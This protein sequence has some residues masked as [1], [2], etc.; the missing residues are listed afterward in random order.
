MPSVTQQLG[1]ALALAAAFSLS[2]AAVAQPPPPPGAG[3]GELQTPDRNNTASVPNA[4][5]AP[6]HDLNITRQPIP[7]VLLAA[8][9]NPYDP[10]RPLNCARISQQLLVLQAALGPDLDEPETPQSPSLTLHNGRI[11]LALLHGA[12]ESL[13][14]FA[15]FV[16]TL[17]G[18]GHHDELVIEAITAGS[19]RR[20]YLKGMG[21]AMNCPHPARPVH[22]LHPP[23]PAREDGP[24]PKY[25]IN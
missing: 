1:A 8:I 18:A 4:V 10:V 9:T 12:A 22:F 2:N 25:P 5:V 15:G 23:P 14:P 7:P 11:A 16:R 17:S 24:A 19:V 6:L 20:G 3:Q 13:L 21:E